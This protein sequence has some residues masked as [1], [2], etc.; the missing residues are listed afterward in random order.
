[1]MIR[2]IQPHLEK[3]VYLL[4]FLSGACGLVCEVIW[5]KY[6]SLFIGNTTHAHMIVL[7]T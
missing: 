7:A 4:F 2:R 3:P 5:E 6:L 1:M